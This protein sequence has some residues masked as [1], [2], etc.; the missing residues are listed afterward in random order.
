MTPHRPQI[1]ILRHFLRQKWIVWYACFLHLLWAGLLLVQPA[2]INATP[3]HMLWRVLDHDTVLVAIVLGAVAVL[4]LQG[5]I[6]R[7]R[8]RWALLLPQQLILLVSAGGSIQAAW[9][10]HYA[11]FTPRSWEFI[12]SDQAPVILAAILYTAAI[13]EAAWTHPSG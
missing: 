11:D 5:S 9:L 3:L 13:V 6:L 7:V 4:A 8:H 1:V 10:H 12:L 2:A